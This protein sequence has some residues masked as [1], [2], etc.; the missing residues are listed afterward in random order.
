MILSTIPKTSYA[1]VVVGG[2]HAGAEAALAAAR[3]GVKTLLVTME[4]SAIALA[5]CNPAIGG[6]AK[7]IVVREVDAM[8]GAMGEITDQSQIQIRM[9]NTSKGPAVRALRAQIDKAL[10][11]HL[12]QEKLFCQ[13]NLDIL[14]AEA[15]ALSLKNGEV[16]GL[17]LSDGSVISC[18]TVVLCSGTYL[19]GQVLMGEES[20][21]SGPV[22]HEPSLLLG[23]YLRG[24][25]LAMTRF[26]T[27]TPARVAKDSIDFSRTQRQDGEKD[28]CFSFLTK[29]GQYNRPSI[30]CWLSW[31]TE[32]THAIIRQNLHLS[33][34]YSG[35][36]QG[37]GPR[38]CPSIED[39]LVRFP[40]RNSHQLFLEPE[41]E[42]S[43]E[44]YV[45]G[46]STSL[47]LWVQEAF[48][49][50]IPGLEKVQ[51]LKPAYAIE[52]D[53]L[54]PLQLSP[55]FAHKEI[56]GLFCA[57]QING[58]SGY[59]EAAGQGLLAGANAAAWVK[60]LAPLVLNRAQAY[61]GVLADDLT[62]KGVDEPYRLF[63]SRAEYRLLLRQNNADLRLTPLAM[64]YGLISPER[65]EAFLSR[66]GEI[67]KE[68]A[69]LEKERPTMAMLNALSIPPAADQTLATLLRRPELTY[70][71]IASL[72]PAPAP[73]SPQSAEE[74]ETMVKYQGYI[75]KQLEQV[76]RFQA[77]EEKRLPLDLDYRSL[78]AL[79][80]EAQEKLNQL[81]PLS[82]GQASRISGV[83]PA[84][85]SV[86][87]FSLK[88]GRLQEKKK[89]E[90][91]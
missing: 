71:K 30:P 23:E 27:G 90:N 41:G 62:T 83:S 91:K 34:L 76:K 61:L 20:F 89:G 46:M 56:K 37:V 88:S 79:S 50:T 13:E 24:E 78:P 53:C 77:L 68:A 3:M 75:E 42:H 2:G 58:T 45:Q 57:G 19:N 25:G 16:Q 70:E 80:K 81:H 44:Y 49:R 74:V 6:P 11:Q 10:Y 17:V 55:T 43:P 64:K 84:D 39:K 40:D 31:T 59:E 87:L 21:P 63:T 66:K 35:R 72:S 69:R 47:P 5:P 9:L 51:I 4:I 65:A 85:L 60:G 67:E 36:I 7:S 32:E 38:Y 26:K 82:I 54:D 29:P 18:P 48:L 52:Y 14:V 15:A 86:L 22:G 28:L 33:P 8:G 12:M 73:L 1:V